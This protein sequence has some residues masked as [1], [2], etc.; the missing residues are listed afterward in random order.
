MTADTSRRSCGALVTGGNGGLGR[1]LARALGRL[2]ARVAVT[3]RDPTTNSAAQRRTPWPSTRSIPATRLLLC[4]PLQ[5]QSVSVPRSRAAFR[6]MASAFA[7][8]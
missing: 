3:R 4:R 7:I 6:R 1:A 5:R 8:A 2:G